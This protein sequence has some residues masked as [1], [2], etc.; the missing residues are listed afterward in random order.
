MVDTY[1]GIDATLGGQNIQLLRGADD[2]PLLFISDSPLEE[3]RLAAGTMKFDEFHHGPGSAVIDQ[4]SDRYLPTN[5]YISALRPGRLELFGASTAS[6]LLV[7]GVTETGAVKADSTNNQILATSFE[8]QG[9][10]YFV[11]PRKVIK[12][13]AGGT[14]GAAQTVTGIGGSDYIRG[15]AAFYQGKYYFGLQDSTG[16]VI[17]H[18]VFDPLA[19]TWTANKNGTTHMKAS[20]FFSTH[21]G[22]WAIRVT[23]VGTQKAQATYDVIFTNAADPTLTANWDTPIAT[24]LRQPFPTAIYPYGKWLLLFG[25]EGEILALA[26][27]PPLLTLL[28]KGNLPSYDF[29]FGVGARLWGGMLVIPAVR[30]LW[31]LGSVQRGDFQS[32]S[33][34]NIMDG[35]GDKA[36]IPASTGIYGSDLLVGLRQD[37]PLFETRLWNLRQYKDGLI[38]HQVHT[39]GVVL[40]ANKG[41]I[42]AIESLVGGKTYCLIGNSAE[43]RIRMANLPPYDGGP[44]S[45]FQA[46]TF[47]SSATHGP[48]LARKR[49]LRARS[50]LENTLSGGASASISAAADGGAF[51]T[52][53]GAGIAAGPIS[54][55]PAA[56]I[57]G[58]MLAVRVNFAAGN[59]WPV[60]LLPI[61]IDYLEEPRKGQRITFYC[62]T[63]AVTTVRRA[64][65]AGSEA[66]A[67]YATLHDFED[68]VQT[69]TLLETPTT[70]NFYVE[71]VEHDTDSP[72][73]GPG[74]PAVALKITGIV[75]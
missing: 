38:Y 3:G 60:I 67:F 1:A 50:W 12:I 69:F 48:T 41:P 11:L 27:L 23:A 54:G 32:L 42:V 72:G 74:R 56:N 25:A 68:T 24:S 16:V 6:D 52:V 5:T 44:P 17:G 43:G 7:D 34:I 21:T 15:P 51:Q 13:T 35:L 4:D 62:H 39:F 47:V 75:V 20:L 64:G 49:V 59:G 2:L 36:F 18:V 22:L 14:T 61:Y 45:G 55:T 40:G 66:L 29:E 53:I 71:T 37:S 65:I 58:N 26:E 30:G 33:P 46:G 73:D 28:P 19:G 9:N 57:V 10:V 8:D 31:G 70:F 63:P